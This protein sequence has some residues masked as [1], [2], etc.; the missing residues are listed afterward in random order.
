MP[1]PITGAG[2]VRLCPPH[3]TNLKGG[4]AWTVRPMAA[5]KTPQGA[6]NQA[7][8]QQQEGTQAQQEVTGNA[9]TDQRRERY[10]CI[11]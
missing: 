8:E 7:Q 9:G 3:E 4:T 10:K 1:V 6:E 11:L 5:R 2:I